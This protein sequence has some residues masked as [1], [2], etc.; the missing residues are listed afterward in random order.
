MS[1]ISPF[2]ARLISLALAAP[3]CASAAA[4]T[5][6]ADTIALS[7][8][9]RPAYL[10]DALPDGALKT[11]LQSCAGQTPQRSDFS[12]A[13]R[14]APLMFPEHTVEGNRAAATM[15]AGIMEC[16][17]TFTKDLELVCRHSQN[18]LHTT[19]DI[20]TSDLADRCT[21]PFAP[22]TADA[23]ASAECRTSDLTLAELMTLHPK[24]DSRDPTATSAAA[25]QGGLAPWRSSLHQDG[26]T[27]LSHAD[28]IALFRNLGAKFTPELKAPTVTMPFNG[29][30]QEAYAQ[31]LIDAYVTA[32]IPASDVWVQSFDLSDIKY[33]LTQTPE[34]GRQAVYL[35]DRFA[36]HD[37]DEGKV[38]PM[39]PATFRP[40]MPEL[41][42]MGLNYIAPP[43]WMLLT[44]E[45]GRMVP[46]PYAKAARE[47][48]LDIITWTLERSGPLKNGGGWYFQSVADVVQSDASTYQVLDVLA[49]DVG[50]V[51]VFSD[52][53]ATVT[54]YANCMGL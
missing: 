41:K 45:D 29:M 21:Q 5:S 19:T 44:L 8:G 6:P 23:P 37:D 50:V 51:G 22:A 33:W 1:R 32:G 12:I 30:T 18:D 48:S 3:L 36:R 17:V 27:L 11:K 4:D 10:V 54:Y 13:H 47:A 43:I 38:D 42:E 28:S 31:K 14:G 7:Y 9:P 52:W 2:C 49:Q 25:F 40:S 20:L 53:P 15:G 39:D 16:D 24:M 46:S 35:D 26:T 34:F